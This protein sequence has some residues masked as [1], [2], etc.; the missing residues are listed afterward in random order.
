MEVRKIV[1]NT[2]KVTL[3][4]VGYVDTVLFEK[5]SNEENV[6]FAKGNISW[7]WSKGHSAELGS[8][9]LYRPCYKLLRT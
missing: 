7:I 1:T 4:V 9:T 8:E 5:C 6:A 3:L 2:T